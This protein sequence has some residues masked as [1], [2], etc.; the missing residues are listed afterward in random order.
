MAAPRPQRPAPGARRAPSLEGREPSDPS[1]R[2]AFVPAKKKGAHPALMISLLGI[3]VVMIGVFAWALVERQDRK[4]QPP[5]AVEND[6]SSQWDG[7]RAQIR[8]AEGKYKEAM[9]LRTDDTQTALFQQKVEEA[10]DFIG[11]VLEEYDMMLEE[12]RDPV[13]G[14]LP[15]EYNGYNHETKPLVV[16]LNDLSHVTNFNITDDDT[17]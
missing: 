15:P 13:T 2:P 6:N 16:W 10:M 4:S 8:I 17:P 11:G 9:A 14:D 5:E 12:V 3:I 7:I 1:G